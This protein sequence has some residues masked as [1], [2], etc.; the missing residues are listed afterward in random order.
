M[1]TLHIYV[2]TLHIKIFSRGGEIDGGP[3]VCAETF[4]NIIAYY[5]EESSVNFEE[6]LEEKIIE[7]N[8]KDCL[9]N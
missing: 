7:I 2:H 4:A 8:F 6:V 1:H 3:Y 9:T 5:T